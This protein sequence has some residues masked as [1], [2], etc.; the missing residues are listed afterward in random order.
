MMA[1]NERAEE[2]IPAIPELTRNYLNQSKLLKGSETSIRDEQIQ[3]FIKSIRLV[4]EIGNK[5]GT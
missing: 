5:L 1:P 3:E 4:A 2:R